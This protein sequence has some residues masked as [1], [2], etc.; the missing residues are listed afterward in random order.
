M[1][2][3]FLVMA[4]IALSNVHSN[5]T[6]TFIVVAP[7]ERHEDCAVSGSP[8]SADW[9]VFGPAIAFPDDTGAVQ[10]PFDV[11]FRELSANLQSG[12]ERYPVE[13]AAVSHGDGSSE[14][15]LIDTRRALGISRQRINGQ[16]MRTTQALTL[17]GEKPL[18]WDARV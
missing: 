13:S 17:G 11:V 2:Y 8:A 7:I 9:N 14:G 15:Q 1:S 18:T 6:E 5:A 4:A 10:K 12:L 16:L 3:R